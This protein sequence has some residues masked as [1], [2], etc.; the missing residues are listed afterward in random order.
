LT[1]RNSPQKISRLLAIVPLASFFL[2]F[3]NTLSSPAAH[4]ESLLSELRSASPA[5]NPSLLL[6]DFANLAD[7]IRRMEQAGMPVLHLDVMDGRF[8]PNIT[9][10]MTIVR[11][12]RQATELPIDVHLMIVEPQDYVQQFCDAGADIV[13]IHAEAVDDPRPVLETIRGCGRLAGLAINPATTLASIEASLPLCDLVL[14]MSVVPGFGGQEFDDVA[15]A[16]TAEL[17]A[18]DD[19]APL[20]EIDGGIN[21]STIDRCVQAGSDLLVAGSAIFRQADS[22]AAARDLAQQA[23]AAKRS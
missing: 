1:H 15:L 23:R 6:C 22:V 14:T 7:E 2:F 19:V 18:R 5:I 11:A 3:G 16:K 17:A 9:Y 10:G 21:A 13:T 4:R 20:L 8:V 12:V